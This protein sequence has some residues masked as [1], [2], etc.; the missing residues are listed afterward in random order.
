MEDIAIIITPREKD[1]GGFS[2]HRILPC[3]SHPM[4]GP[5]IFFDHLGP[6]QFP[7]GHGVDVRPHPH[8]NLAT[9]TYLFDGKIQHRDSLGSDQLIEPGAIN[10]MTAGHGIVH[11][12]RTPENLRHSENTLHG[13]QCWVALP[14]QYEEV[15]PEFSHYKAETLPEFNLGSVQ[16]KL[17]LGRVFEYKSPVKI[18]S[19]LFYLEVKIP[20]ETEFNF[21][22][23]GRDGAV[24]VV[25]GEVSVN[26]RLIQ[27]HTMVVNQRCKKFNIKG[28]KNSHLMLLGGTPVGKR[29]I[30]WNF[31]SSSQEK[32]EQ[33]KM[34]WANG[35]GIPGSRFPKVPHDD[36]EFIPLP[37]E[38][39]S[40]NP[41]GTIM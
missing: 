21:D 34:D 8:I 2:V 19:D 12:E 10:W 15:A 33:A 29:Y 35:P 3:A 32:I 26:Q 41:K 22:L 23:E 4:V 14:E 25:D 39:P 30:Y 28:S 40:K 13:I 20:E 37:E 38:E 1:L 17:L 11:S 5:F 27:P 24:Y 9:V 6:A 36:K 7:K 16:L 18:H 31:V